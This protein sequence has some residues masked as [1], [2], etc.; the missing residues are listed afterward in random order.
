MTPHQN[1]PRAWELP[2]LDAAERI[3]FRFGNGGLRW[4]SEGPIVLLQHGWQ[5][6]PTQFRHLIAPLLA[7]GR[8]VIALDAPAHGRSP[9][10]E[11]HP[12]AFAEAMLEA[13]VELRDIETVIGHSMGGSAAL[14]A[15]DRGLPASRAVV[16][17]APASMHRVLHRFAQTIALNEPSEEQFLRLVDA[18]VGVP[19]HELDIERMAARHALPA[20]IVHD[21]DDDMVPF[22][23]AEALAR[24]WPGSRL[25][26]TQGLGHREVLA[27]AGVVA[28]IVSFAT[29]RE[30]HARAA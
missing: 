6:R 30:A 3:T 15:L 24:G 18:H 14:I 4:G 9:G 27:D 8:Q 5:G 29:A 12:V 26:A 2:A 1:P 16:I 7:A 13:A 22:A 11:A 28:A 23:E 19:A 20:L 25:L 10:H 21:R 17:G